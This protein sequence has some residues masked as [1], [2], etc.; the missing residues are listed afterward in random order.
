MEYPLLFSAGHLSGSISTGLPCTS[1]K[2]ANFREGPAAMRWMMECR[3]FRGPRFKIHRKTWYH[4]AN[5]PFS[6]KKA[7]TDQNQ[8]IKQLASHHNQKRIHFRCMC[9]GLE[10]AF[11]FELTNAHPFL[12]F[13]QWISSIVLYH[14]S[15]RYEACRLT[16]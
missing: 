7:D 8:L 5:P 12:S 14:K 2:D 15:I 1:P 3:W 16:L 11:S 6:K 4:A 13:G 10:C 9:S